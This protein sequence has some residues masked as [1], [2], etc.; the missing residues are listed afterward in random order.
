MAHGHPG[1]RN[2]NYLARS[3]GILF[4]IP[5]VLLAVAVAIVPLELPGIQIALVWLA[6]ALASGGLGLIRLG[7]HGRPHFFV[8]L[9]YLAIV[10]LILAV[11]FGVRAYLLAI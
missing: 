8:G 11:I 1:V 10:S 3:F 7:S 6:T 5:G 2:A 4:L 9:L